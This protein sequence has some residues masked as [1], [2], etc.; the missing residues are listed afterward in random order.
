MLLFITKNESEQIVIPSER[1][2]SI[3]REKNKIVFIYNNAE[4]FFADTVNQ[5]VVLKATS[6]VMRYENE[7][8]AL[9]KMREF[10]KA[11]VKDEKA[12]HF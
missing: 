7:N 1:I 10:Y 5:P 12:F 6:I 4:Y 11:S 2:Y 8:D 9:K 3:K